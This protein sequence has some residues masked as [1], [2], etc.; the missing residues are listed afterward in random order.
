MG[1]G[2]A[3]R[4]AASGLLA[5][6]A[7]PPFGLWPLAFVALVPLVRSCTAPD[8][9]RDD[10]VRAGLAFGALFYGTL[11][12]WVPFTLQGMLPLGALQGVLLLGILAGVGGLQGVALRELMRIRGLSPFVVLPAVWVGMEFLFSV[13][14]PLA[15][16]WLPLGLALASAPALA[17]ISE[18][19]GPG[20]LTLWIALVNASLLPLF[21]G[22]GAVRRT[23]SLGLLILLA[24]GPA[25][26]GAWR[27]ESLPLEPLPPIL[28]VQLHLSREALLDPAAR[29]RAAGASLDRVLDG[30]MQRQADTS[31]PLPILA[32]LPEAPYATAWN[33]AMESTLR[34]H[35]EDLGLPLLWGTHLLDSP[36]DGGGRDRSRGRRNGAVMI[37]ADGTPVEVLH[38]KTRLVP[39]VERP[40]L[41][42]GERGGVTEFRGLPV[43]ILL[44]FEAAF[45]SEFRRL[46]QA[47]AR[48]LVN[49][50]NDGWYR[51]AWMRGPGTAAHSQHRAHLVLRA[52][53]TRAA[54]VRASLGGE[55]LVIDP[56]G[57]VT[58]SQPP[59]QEGAMIV[60]PQGSSVETLF[61]RF[62]DVG[63]AAGLLLLG[64][65]FLLPARRRRDASPVHEPDR[66]PGGLRGNNESG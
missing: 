21:F 66:S 49:P 52:V 5:A 27:A 22:V 11:L 24:G 56:S 2:P 6:L 9:D 63:G 64:G 23:V 26:W 14:G 20:A 57:R 47:G 54:A 58:D 38:E 53:E 62:G 3:V 8:G 12:H 55:L 32:V 41:A 17:G 34:A 51:P 45:A 46:R 39:G 16:P 1:S 59:G 31:R 19:F 50:S 35:A 42:V 18:L 7:L 48:L 65:A 44:C 43:G 15:F 30:F 36:T 61:V 29:D 25:A 33:P 37:P 10:A 4:G 13:A 28:L 60:H 40:G